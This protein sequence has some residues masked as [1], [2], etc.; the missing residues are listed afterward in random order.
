MSTME[1]RVKLPREMVA[2]LAA[3]SVRRDK[4]VNLLIEEAISKMLTPDTTPTKE[5]QPT[6]VVVTSPKPVSSSPYSKYG[7]KTFSTQEDKPAVLS[8]EEIETIADERPP[9]K[10]NM[11]TFLERC[12]ELLM[13][14]LTDKDFKSI[15]DI[16]D[17]SNPDAWKSISRIVVNKILE[18]GWPSDQVSKWVWKL[19][20]EVLSEENVLF[21]LRELGLALEYQDF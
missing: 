6:P 12:R 3:L 17:Y 2:E 9:L 5:C 19:E 13:K 7:G 10:V 8:L 21:R 4:K 20:K 18:E 15:R 11:Y 14:E 16:C 1:I